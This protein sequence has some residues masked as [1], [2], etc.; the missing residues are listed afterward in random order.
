MSDRI[1]NVDEL[2]LHGEALRD[3]L[4]E[5]PDPEGLGRVVAA[6]EEMHAVL[7]RL[8]HHGL[9]GLSGHEGIE[10]ELTSLVDG[11][12]AATGDYPDARDALRTRVEDEW[13]LADGLGEPAA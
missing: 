1:R 3:Q 7:P 5:P 11:E 2:V 10:A 12:R 8:S 6:G 9:A 13:L 4:A